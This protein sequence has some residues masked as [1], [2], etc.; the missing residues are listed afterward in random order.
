MSDDAIEDVTM[1]QMTLKPISSTNKFSP[2]DQTRKHSTDKTRKVV[3]KKSNQV[4][5]SDVL[6][7][8]RPTQK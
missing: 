7:A 5:A 4:M 1:K 8:L 3:S 6:K 2:T